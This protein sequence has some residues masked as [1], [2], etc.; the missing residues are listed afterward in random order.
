MTELLYRNV[1]RQVYI[2]NVYGQVQKACWLKVKVKV[3]SMPI[4]LWEMFV[5]KVFLKKGI[6]AD[7]D[8]L[9]ADG[10]RAEWDAISGNILTL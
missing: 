5:C 3:R 10:L 6:L 2:Y 9:G 7:E 4:K 1:S 8:G